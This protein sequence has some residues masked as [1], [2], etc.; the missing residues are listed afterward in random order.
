MAL[1]ALFLGV[2]VAFV[3]VLPIVAVPIIALSVALYD[4]GKGFFGSL[5]HPKN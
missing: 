4:F 1:L 3:L 5:I 2:L